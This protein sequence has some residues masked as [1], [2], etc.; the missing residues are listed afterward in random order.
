ML[1]RGAE[2]NLLDVHGNS[3]FSLAALERKKFLVAELL[4]DHGADIDARNRDGDSALHLAGS[5]GRADSADL[6]IN[7]GIEINAINMVGETALRVASGHA[8]GETAHMLIASA[9]DVNV[10]DIYGRKA[11]WVAVHCE[12]LEITK[13]QIETTIDLNQ[14]DCDGETAS[15]NAAQHGDEALVKVLLDAGA[16][17]LP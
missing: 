17:I 5:L 14:Q 2:V 8:K 10:T 13:L 4:L 3:L 1:A 9:A 11:L 6:L 16:Q 15:S 7:Y 12:N